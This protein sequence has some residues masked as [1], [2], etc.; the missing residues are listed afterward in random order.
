MRVFTDGDG[1]GRDLDTPAGVADTR[2][3]PAARP[4]GRRCPPR[5]SAPR[6]S[7][8]AALTSPTTW[9]RGGRRHG[10]RLLPANHPR[11]RT[12]T[13]KK[14][15]KEKKSTRRKRRE[16]GRAA[17]RALLAGSAGGGCGGGGGVPGARRGAAR[18]GWAD[19][20][21]HG[22]LGKTPICATKEEEGG[23]WRGCKLFPSPS[24]PP[25]AARPLAAP[26]GRAAP[27]APFPA[28]RP[29]GSRR[30][31]AAGFLT[32]GARR[33]RRRRGSWFAEPAEEGK[34]GGRQGGRAGG[35]GGVSPRALPQ[36]ERLSRPWRRRRSPPLPAALRAPRSAPGRA[37]GA[38]RPWTGFREEAAP[39]RWACA[40]LRPPPRPCRA[41]GSRAPLGPPACPRRPGVAPGRGRVPAALVRLRWSKPL[42]VSDIK[43][44]KNRR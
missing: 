33:R 5:R 31:G 30:R 29:G 19:S 41:G 38:R 26:G 32:H 13:K 27:A 44:K 28:A 39:P 11:A 37:A 4:S 20:S 40:F 18:R 15:K 24:A 14:K 16:R 21:H 2:P 22:R 35:G 8:R 9:W 23:E 12:G 3:A 1:T 25:G 34:E 42:L 43:K 10:P 7:V 36:A 17:G 6:A